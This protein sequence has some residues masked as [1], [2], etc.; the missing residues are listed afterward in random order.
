MREH[1]ARAFPRNGSTI[2][3]E[4]RMVRVRENGKDHRVSDD[5]DGIRCDVKVKKGVGERLVPLRALRANRQRLIAVGWWLIAV[6]GGATIG[7][8]GVGKGAVT[9]LGRVT[10]GYESV[11]NHQK[12]NE[13]WFFLQ[14]T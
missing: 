7:A 3:C 9:A 2:R 14:V 11:K 1:M 10:T 13:I 12:I 8:S 5:G 6:I 4:V